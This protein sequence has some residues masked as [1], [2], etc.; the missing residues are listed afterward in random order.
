MEESLD[1]LSKFMVNFFVLRPIYDKDVENLKKRIESLEWHQQHDHC[2]YK[3]SN[4][5]C[6]NHE[7]YDKMVK[8]DVK[9]GLL[10]CSKTCWEEHP[11]YQKD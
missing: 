3:C 5:K 2:Y 7:L 1:K 8:V 9:K 10:F 6:G 4:E 11:C